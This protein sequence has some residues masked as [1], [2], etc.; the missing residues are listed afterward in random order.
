M[1]TYLG[2]V[3]FEVRASANKVQAVLNLPPVPDGTQVYLDVRLSRD[4]SVKA[5]ESG[6]EWISEVRDG[7]RLVLQPRRS[8]STRITADSEPVDNQRWALCAKRSDRP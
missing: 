7:C 3:D 1:T 5:V 4:R 2:P 8:E 6:S